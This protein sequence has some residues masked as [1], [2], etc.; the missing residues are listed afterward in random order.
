[1]NK[2]YSGGCH[3]GAVHFEAD[4]DIAAGTTKCNCSICAQVRFWSVEGAPGDVRLLR[5]AE[6]LVDYRFN[7]GNV[8]HYFCRH[9]GVRPYQYV[10]LPAVGRCYYNVNIACL[11]GVDID[12]LLAAPINY[13]DGRHDR[14]EAVPAEIRHL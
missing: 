11:E 7:T 12:E 10:D 3:C 13:P 14:W 2:R 1:M 6:D 5:G 9:C 8:H 4:V